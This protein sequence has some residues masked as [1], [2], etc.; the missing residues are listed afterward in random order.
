MP[1][2]SALK[3]DSRDGGVRILWMDDP[4]ESQN[5]LKVSLVEEFERVLDQLRDDPQ[6]RVLVFISAK[7]AGFQYMAVGSSAMPT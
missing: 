5:T 7:P 3:L 4:Q 6:L 2:E 1:A